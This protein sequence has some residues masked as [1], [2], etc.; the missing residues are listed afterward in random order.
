MPTLTIRNLPGEVHAR[1]RIR[2][3]HAG[4]SMEAEVRVIL[5]EAVAP[6]AGRMT[7]QVLRDWVDQAYGSEKPSGVV[8]ELIAERRRESTRE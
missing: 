5:E 8:E 3:A 6:D 4:R 7:V 1:L 2:A